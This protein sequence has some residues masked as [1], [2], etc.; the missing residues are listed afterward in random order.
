MKKWQ[1]PE[2]SEETSAM[3]CEKLA[4]KHTDKK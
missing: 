1:K 3:V 4:V 2:K